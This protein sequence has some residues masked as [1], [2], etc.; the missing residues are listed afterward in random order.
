MKKNFIH[1]EGSKFLLM[2]LLFLGL[3]LVC[4]PYNT[5]KGTPAPNVTESALYLET[6][7]II[8]S[9][10]VTLNNQGILVVLGNLT[11]NG[12]PN[13]GSGTVKFTGS[14]TQSINGIS[15]FQ[16]LEVN[17]ATGVTIN[18]ATT[19]N[20]T[21]TL[22]NGLVTLGNNILLLGPSAN[23]A[24]T[25]DAT[26][27]IVATGSGQMRKQFSGN[28]SFTFPVGDNTGTAEYSPVILNFTSGTYGSGNWAG[29]NLVN[30][31][32]PG[33]TG[34]YLKRYWIVSSNGISGFNCIAKFNY[35]FPADVIGL[36]S[37]IYCAKVAPEPSIIYDITNTSLHQLTANGLSSFGTFTGKLGL[38]RLNIAS[39]MLEGLYN[40]GGIMR[41]AYDEVGEHFGGD[42]ADVIKVELHKASD[43]SSIKYTAN[44]VGL[45]TSGI[46]S[47]NVPGTYNES[48]YVTIKHRNSI[49]TTTSTPVLLSAAVVN[50][51]FNL[52]AK[53]YGNNLGIMEDGAAVI[54]GGDS[55]QDGIV[56]GGD[57][58]DT[59]NLAEMGANGYL[60]E[61]FTGDGLVDGSDLSL[62]GNNATQGV[63]AIT[64]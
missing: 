38:R 32:Y 51:S 13:L 22:A 23:V 63:G 16:N 41:K 8:L 6:G 9:G 44:N 10:G 48:Y 58:S 7:D 26:K 54:F 19:V 21:L 64:P 42:T 35:L 49:E 40:G 5:V 50:Y 3:Q 14:T 29:V 59:G 39:L 25:P 28:G 27:M 1:S 30:S 47:I 12:A 62:A 45:S 46:A 34:S 11:N 36:E 43:Y 33:S 60:P 4:I 61:D 17:N 52:P 53:A 24:G 15:T 18:G 37:E 57:L 20:G 55:N 56:D 31:L 2:G